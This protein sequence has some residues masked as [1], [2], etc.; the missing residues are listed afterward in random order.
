MTKADMKTLIKG[1]Q[2]KIRADGEMTEVLED[3]DE[4]TSLL[5]EI[6]DEEPHIRVPYVNAISIG[7]TPWK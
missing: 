3:I 4:I 7:G 1:L 5:N 2:K 6:E